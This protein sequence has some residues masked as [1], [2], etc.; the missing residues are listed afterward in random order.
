MSYLEISRT[1]KTNIFQVGVHREIKLSSFSVSG[2]EIVVNNGLAQSIQ[3][4]SSD[5]TEKDGGLWI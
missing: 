3:E 2:A 4:L 1:N 5:E